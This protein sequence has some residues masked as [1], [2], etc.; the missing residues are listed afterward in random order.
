MAPEQSSF[1]L[2]AP[3]DIRSEK[4]TFKDM[5]IRCMDRLHTISS[6]MMEKSSWQAVAGYE[7]SIALLHSY[8]S[9]YYD[10]KY[11]SAVSL[12]EQ[13]LEAKPY[14]ADKEYIKLLRAWVK[15]IVKNIGRVGL[16]PPIDIELD[17]ATPDQIAEE[18]QEEF[19][20]IMKKL[21]KNNRKEEIVKWLE[22]DGKIPVIKREQKV[23]SISDIIDPAYLQ[24]KV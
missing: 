22:L 1:E 4:M 15:L 5:I 13:K 9:P 21:C 17:M 10:E 2:I 11:N 8:V 14:S 7:E 16:L 3:E 12:I 19:L 20:R 6:Q 18:E 23:Y 24:K